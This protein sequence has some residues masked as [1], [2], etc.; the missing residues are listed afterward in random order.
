MLN[1]LIYSMHQISCDQ[2]YDLVFSTKNGY[3]GYGNSAF[4]SRVTDLQICHSSNPSLRSGT[5]RRLC[6]VI[7]QYDKVARQN[8]SCVLTAA[9]LCSFS[10]Q[11]GDSAARLCRAAC[12]IVRQSRHCVRCLKYSETEHSATE[13]ETRVIYYGNLMI[14]SKSSYNSA[15]S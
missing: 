3:I 12:K 2:L 8:P 5:H 10:T 9:L 4:T 13:M 14:V 11:K 7:L 15:V 1:V 6:R